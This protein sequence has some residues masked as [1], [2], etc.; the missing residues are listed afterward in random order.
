[1]AELTGYEA[2]VQMADADE[3]SEGLGEAERPG[4]AEEAG[5]AAEETEAAEAEEFERPG[6]AET[7]REDEDLWAAGRDGRGIQAGENGREFQAGGDGQRFQ[8][9]GVRRGF[10]GGGGAWAGS[11][12]GPGAEEPDEEPPGDAVAVVPVAVG[13]VRG[14]MFEARLVPPPLRPERVYGG[15]VPVAAKSG[16]RRAEEDPSASDWLNDAQETDGTDVVVPIE[17]RPQGSRGPRKVALPPPVASGPQEKR[18]SSLA[19]PEPRDGCS[20]EWKGTWLWEVCKK[21][22]RQEV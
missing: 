14:R 22:G 7:D 17:T 9:G 1:M 2:A 5:E 3:E 11:V 10:Q 21:R 20:A 4:K 18:T 15:W 16:V 13:P 8:A 6:E 19:P 12:S